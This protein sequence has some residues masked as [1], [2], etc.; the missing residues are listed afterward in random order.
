MHARLVSTFVFLGLTAVASGA[1]FAQNVPTASAY[2]PALAK[3]LGADERG[4]RTY[5]LV[6]L[7]TGPN[8]IA[9]G[10]ERDKMFEGHFANMERLAAAGKL[11]LAGPSDGV[12]GWRG[13]FVFATD[14]IEQ[15]KALV[16]TD[17]VIAKGEMIAEYHQLYASAG[18][19]L[20]NQTHS[21]IQ[22]R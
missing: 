8:K 1:A 22:K 18:L 4:M 3:S 5:V 21:K 15:A 6:I 13:I 17:P 10:P 19:M 7:K 16:A 11:A 12:D 9:A 2:D 14:D 20:V